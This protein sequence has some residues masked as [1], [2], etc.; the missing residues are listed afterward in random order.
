MKV[1]P[2]YKKIYSSY[3]GHSMHQH[4]QKEETFVYTDDSRIR[5]KAAG[6]MP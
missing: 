1:L 4:D 3:S 5:T 2:R 6:A